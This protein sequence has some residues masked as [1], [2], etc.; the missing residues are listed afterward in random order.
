METNQK[1][2]LIFQRQWLKD[3]ILD[4]I[5]DNVNYTN[6]LI[7][8]NFVNYQKGKVKNVTKTPLLRILDHIQVTPTSDLISVLSDSKHKILTVF[9]FEPA[10]TRF[11][12]DNNQRITMNT[13]G[14]VILITKAN[15]KFTNKFKFRKFSGV[16]DRNEFF[17][18]FPFFASSSID[19]VFLEVI[20]FEIFQRDQCNTGDSIFK[21]IKYVYFDPK[22]K[23]KFKPVERDEK[24]KDTNEDTSISDTYDDCISL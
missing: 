12:L 16:T 2:P 18:K 8:P 19:I 22:Y 10:I 4:T 21:R 24:D 20:E 23:D 1:Y 17:N 13:R 9:P 7:K 6:E 15:L 3:L 11:E 14:T 5:K